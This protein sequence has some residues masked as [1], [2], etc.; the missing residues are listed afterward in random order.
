MKNQDFFRMGTILYAAIGAI[1]WASGFQ[2]G[3]GLFI[4]CVIA[5]V[6]TEVLSYIVRRILKS[7]DAEQIK[8]TQVRQAI[9][10]EDDSELFI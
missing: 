5:L 9:H 2:I 4:L 10:R 1:T 8:E 7:K 3:K 6:V